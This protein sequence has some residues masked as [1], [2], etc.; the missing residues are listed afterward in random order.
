MQLALHVPLECPD[1]KSLFPVRRVSRCSF[2]SAA[3]ASAKSYLRIKDQG[4]SHIAGVCFYFTEVSFSESR[5]WM[6][7]VQTAKERV[8]RKQT[9][10]VPALTSLKKW[11]AD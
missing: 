1:T 10:H 9:L 3:M 2:V 7:P 8:F 5:H 11:S 6:S 4:I